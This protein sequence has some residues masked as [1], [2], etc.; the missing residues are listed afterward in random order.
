MTRSTRTLVLHLVAGLLGALALTG[1][2]AVFGL[3]L[4]IPT[5]CTLGV[6][7][8]AG[9]WLV[10]VE[11]ARADS[12]DPPPLDLDVDYALPHGQDMRVRRLEDVIHGA[13]PHRRMT[14]RAL[15]RT[16]ADVAEDRAR[17]PRAAPLSPALSGLLEQVRD[18]GTDAESFPP[19]DRRTLHQHLRELSDTG[20]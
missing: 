5:M 20:E 13:Q 3:F 11:P 7:A 10:R 17:D 6:A 2:C 16:L 4:S 1:V 15:A 9:L 12:L 14:A 8:G 18:P 19:I